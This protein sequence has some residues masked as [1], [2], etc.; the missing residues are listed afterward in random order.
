MMDAQYF[1]AT[2]GSMTTAFNIKVKQAANRW[3]MLRSTSNVRVTSADRSCKGSGRPCALNDVAHC[4][5]DH[6]PGGQ[7]DT[8]SAQM[9]VTS[10]LPVTSKVTSIINQVNQPQ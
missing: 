5:A 8:Y 4:S 9:T 1:S 10:K 6:G 7:D 3:A 2:Y